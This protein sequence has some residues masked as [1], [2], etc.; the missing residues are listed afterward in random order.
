LLAKLK[1]ALC[2]EDL[3]STGRQVRDRSTRPS[4]GPPQ[5]SVFSRLSRPLPLPGSP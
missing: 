1:R 2:I 4:S 3:E 5:S